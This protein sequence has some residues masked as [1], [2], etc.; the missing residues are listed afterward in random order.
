MSFRSELFR[1]FVREVYPRL[2]KVTD[3]AKEHPL[4]QETFWKEV[5][6]SYKG[7]DPI[8][9]QHYATLEL[10]YGSS[11]A[12]VKSAYKALMK[13]YHPDKFQDQ[14]KKV[15]ATELVQKLNEAYASLNKHLS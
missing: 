12:E 8:I 14:E 9:K 11:L 5:R 2:E 4:F 6:A 10:P 15:A 7:E 13:Q 3:A 1:L